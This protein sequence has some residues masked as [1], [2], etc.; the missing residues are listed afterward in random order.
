[1]FHLAN[2]KT[3]LFACIV[4][5]ATS[6]CKKDDADDNNGTN[7]NTVN[8]NPLTTGSTWTYESNDG[9]SYTLTNSGR[10]TVASSRTYK[11]LT[12]SNGPNVY[13]AK[14]VTD[15]YQYI[16]IPELGSSGIEALYLK[17]DAAVNA[18]WQHSQLLSVPNIPLPLPATFTYT[19]KEKGISRTVKGKAYADVIHVGL[20]VSVTGLGSLGGGE[21]YY[22]KGIGLIEGSLKLSFSGTEVVNQTNLLTSYTI[23]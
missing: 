15:H 19:V 10:D 4:L 14:S 1:M 18:T 22:A 8:Y 3:L 12:N 17:E 5:L 20:V 11:V 6:G 21:F 13:K 9:T 23:K 2:R 7:N 16:K